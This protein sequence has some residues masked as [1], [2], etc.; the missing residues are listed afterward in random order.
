MGIF[1]K[2]KTDE[3]KQRELFEKYGLDI[4]NYDSAQIQK[5]N[6][7]NLKQIATD[8]AMSGINKF[9]MG[10]TMSQPDHAKVQYLSSIFETNLILIRQNEL[11]IRALN[12]IADKK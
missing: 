8:L 4:D 3:E 1:G 5:E 12:K 10:L 11:I 7:K 6:A 9:A 2:Q